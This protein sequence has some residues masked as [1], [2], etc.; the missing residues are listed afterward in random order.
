MP[1]LISNE[2][3]GRGIDD[4][5]LKSCAEKILA[6]L[7]FEKKELSVLIVG[8]PEIQQ[9][10][11]QYR[12]IDSATDVLSF[13]QFEGPGAHS[14]LLGDVVLS[15]DTAHRQAEEHGLALEEE[16][17]LLLIH[18]ILHLAGYDH[19]RSQPEARRMQQKSRRLFAMICPGK[20]PSDSCEY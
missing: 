6:E 2:N 4:Q 10:N 16:L 13:S 18:G 15:R 17:I 3:D 19:E 5:K 20:K 11:R 9:L 8:D 1:V 12:N 14:F 7:G